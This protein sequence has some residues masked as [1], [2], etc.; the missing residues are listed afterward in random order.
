MHTS[1]NHG[2]R[3]LALS[4]LSAATLTSCID[5]DLS[6]CGKDYKVD[7][8]VQL[9]TNISTEIETELTTDIERQFGVDLSS[10]LA[11][12]FTDHARDL[13]LSFYTDDARLAQHDTHQMDASQASYTIFLPVRRY[14]NL[15]IANTAVEPNVTIDGLQTLHSMRLVQTE[16]VDTV[17]SQQVGLFSA[18]LPMEIEN[19][20]Q[21]FHVNLYMQNCTA[22]L[23]LDP[24]SVAISD[25]RGCVTGLASSFAVNDS[26]YS[27]DHSVPIRANKLRASNGRLIGLYATGFPSRD[28]RS[29]GLPSAEAP[30]QSA[31]AAQR[32]P[33]RADEADNSLWQIKVYVRLATGQ[34]TENTLYIREPLRAGRLRIIKA[35]IRDDGSIVTTTQNVGVSVKLDWKPGGEHDVEV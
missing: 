25:V 18:R 24:G 33:L 28:T 13:D 26:V 2:I 14:Q 9:R 29:G 23:V 10:T 8:T 4:L 16:N 15:A 21:E 20:D 12:V 22:C 7:Y 34:T 30:Q 3:L 11:D 17:P 19:R 1:I 6:D 32:P 35:A 31:I 5:E 27:F